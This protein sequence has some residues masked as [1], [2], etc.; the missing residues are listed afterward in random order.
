MGQGMVVCTRGFDIVVQSATS[1]LLSEVCR[2]M[3]FSSWLNHRVSL[4]W[5][6]E[7]DNDPPAAQARSMSVPSAFFGAAST[8]NDPAQG[9]ERSDPPEASSMSSP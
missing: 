1:N 6:E 4:A 8:S 3:C 7:K 9:K 2:C 5:Q